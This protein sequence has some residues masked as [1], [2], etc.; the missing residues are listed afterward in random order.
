MSEER[1]RELNRLRFD[2]LRRLYDVSGGRRDVIV[3]LND[4]ANEMGIDRNDAYSL[5]D[6]LRGEYLLEFK[7]LGPGIAITHHGV[8]EIE[9]AIAAPDEPTTYFPPVNLI[10][11]GSMSGSQ[12]QQG[13]IAS[14]QS[15]LI[16]NTDPALLIELIA[17]VR[18]ALEEL[19]LSAEQADELESDLA[20]LEA[21]ATS[22]RP[23][24]TIVREAL[25]SIRTILEGAAGQVAASIL[26]NMMTG[27]G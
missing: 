25:S 22:P 1:I 24:S 21:Q 8:K 7:T 19:Q 16:A 14:N 9:S 26:I 12:I 4:L 10:Y 6:W 11:V 20:T 17:S 5:A 23:K 15:Q 13:T 3:A 27:I 2:L 18:E